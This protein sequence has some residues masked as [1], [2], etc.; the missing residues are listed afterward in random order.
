M[1]DVRVKSVVKW[2]PYMSAG[3]L[4]IEAQIERQMMEFGSCVITDLDRFMMPNLNNC[5]INGNEIH[6]GVDY[7]GGSVYD[8]EPNW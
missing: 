3:S 2:G 6:N 8:F 4:G 1:L 5:D 7:F